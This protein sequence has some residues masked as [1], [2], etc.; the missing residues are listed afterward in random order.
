VGEPS[1]R[2]HDDRL[3][4]WFREDIRRFA[5]S[6]PD[7]DFVAEGQGEGGVRAAFGEE[8]YQRLAIK[9][10]YDSDHV[11]RGNQNIRPTAVVEALK[12]GT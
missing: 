4:A 7:L 12:V 5:S 1:R 10:Q 8:K 11:L 3:G 2:R 9:A 6:G